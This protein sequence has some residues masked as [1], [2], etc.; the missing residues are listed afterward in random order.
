MIE[1][2]RFQKTGCSV[3]TYPNG[4]RI[5]E[6]PTTTVV[7]SATAAKIRRPFQSTMAIFGTSA[8]FPAFWSTPPPCL[9]RHG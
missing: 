6:N 9:F 7:S 1:P 3:L 2:C 4:V 8:V 5:N